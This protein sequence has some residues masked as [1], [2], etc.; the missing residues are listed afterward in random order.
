VEAFYSVFYI[1]PVDSIVV[2]QYIC[3]L[4]ICFGVARCLI[5]MIFV[6]FSVLHFFLLG[7][8]DFVVLFVLFVALFI[9]SGGVIVGVFHG[10]FCVLLISGGLHC[11]LFVWWW[12]YSCCCCLFL[13]VVVFVV[14]YFFFY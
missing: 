2:S 5:S 14:V 1:Y 6:R 8:P 9:N 3:L 11:L 4:L 7:L 10:D 12:W 13:Y